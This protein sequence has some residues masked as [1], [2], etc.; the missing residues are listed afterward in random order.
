MV[1]VLLNA[2]A[3]PTPQLLHTGL[4]PLHMCAFQGDTVIAEKLILAGANVN[5]LDNA[6]VS[7]LFVAAARGI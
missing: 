1:D 3:N 2:G 4:T 7:A 6:G 5:E